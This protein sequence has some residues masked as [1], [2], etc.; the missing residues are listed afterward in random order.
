MSKIIIEIGEENES[1]ASEPSLRT[2]VE[3]NVTFPLLLQVTAS[4]ILSSAKQIEAAANRDKLTETQI[5]TLKK[6]LY[7]TLNITF[8]N[9]LTMFAPEIERHPDITE[10]AIA[11]AELSLM[12][13]LQ[14]DPT[15]AS[16]RA[17]RQAVKNKTEETRKKLEAT[18]TVAE[19]LQQK[20]NKA[21]K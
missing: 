2:K 15:G 17:E 14:K 9:V 12:E 8:G 1:G 19:A 13:E 3:G 5:K 11:R 16:I 21:N 7:D 20:Q 4:L 10:D 6:N 18:Y